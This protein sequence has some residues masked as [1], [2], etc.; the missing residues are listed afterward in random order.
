MAKPNVLWLFETW[1]AYIFDEE[2]REKL[3]A[4][5]EV[6]SFRRISPE[7]NLANVIK[8]FE[9][10][11][12]ILGRYTDG[13]LNKGFWQMLDGGGMFCFMILL[14]NDSIPLTTRLHCLRSFEP[15]FRKLFAVR[16]TPHLSHLDQPGA[17]AL[18]SVCY[19]WW[20][21]IAFHGDPDDPERKELDAA[22]LEVMES[23][24]MLDSLPCLESALHGLGHWQHCYPTRVE[25]IIDTFIPILPAEIAR[26][27]VNAQMGMVQ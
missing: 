11:L 24:L 26:Y 4:D 1:V 9:E 6:I 21:I 13:Q 19:M 25:Q 7:T 12:P 3:E 17:S 18:N 22:A 2:E 23:I 10:P 8:L 15:L 27:A 16:C 20:D 5:E 14:K